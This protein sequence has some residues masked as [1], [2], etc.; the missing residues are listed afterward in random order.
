MANVV[1]HKVPHDGNYTLFWDELNWQAVCDTCHN[2][3]CA[4]KDNGIEVKKIN[5]DGSP[6]GEGWV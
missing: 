3:V 6:E 5:N 2:S 4:K 1:D